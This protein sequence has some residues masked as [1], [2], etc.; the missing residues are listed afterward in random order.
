MLFPEL[1]STRILSSQIVSL[2][3]QLLKKD[4]SSDFKKLS[5]LLKKHD[6][7][8]VLQNAFKTLLNSKSNEAI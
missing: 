2:S 4:L 6:T 1:V 5:T 8:Q 7:T 3:K